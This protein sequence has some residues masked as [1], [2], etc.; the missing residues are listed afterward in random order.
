MKENNL[1]LKFIDLFTKLHTSQV[2]THI[3]INCR[4]FKTRSEISELRDIII[5]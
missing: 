5:L 4:D 2:V 1:Y 3:C